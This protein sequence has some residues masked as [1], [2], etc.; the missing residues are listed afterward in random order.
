MEKTG[1]VISVNDNTATV[2]I[3]RAT[4]C[5]ENCASCGGCSSARQ[6]IKAKNEIGAKK[7]DMV[8]LEI[9]DKNVLLAAFFVYIVPIFIL[10][11]GIAIFGGV[12]GFLAFAA[13]FVV[14]HIIDKRLALRYTATITKAWRSDS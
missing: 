2:L 7:G 4:A 8:R 10:A 11:A 5:G 14:L 6:A 9:S 1:T 12:A 13:A 3:V